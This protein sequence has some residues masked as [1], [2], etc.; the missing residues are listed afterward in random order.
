MSPKLSN[1]IKK[2]REYDFDIGEKMSYLQPII[3]VFSLET[4]CI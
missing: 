1:M 4:R 2:I 3:I